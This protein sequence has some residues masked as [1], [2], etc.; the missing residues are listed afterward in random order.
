MRRAGDQ[1]GNLWWRLLHGE[2]PVSE[3]TELSSGKDGGKAPRVV[4]VLIGTNDL[5]AAD[6]HRNASELLEAAPGIVQRCGHGHSPQYQ[7]LLLWMLG[8][9]CLAGGSSFAEASCQTAGSPL[10]G[11]GAGCAAHLLPRTH[12]LWVHLLLRLLAPVQEGR[13]ACM[14]G[15]A[16]LG[17]RRT[18]AVLRALRAGLPRAHIVLQALLPR[19]MDLLP[20]LRFAWPN[21]GTAALRAVNAGFAALAE[22]GAGVH[23]VDCGTA[24]VERAGAGAAIAKARCP[25]LGLPLCLSCGAERASDCLSGTAVTAW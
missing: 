8:S 15:A 18:A 9:A 7:L 4:F 3:D 16:P 12:L 22:A 19:G 23:Y 21:R 25:L 17:R 20:Y 11:R 5:G 6:C 10:G 1:I 2:L 24:F 14:T 13:G